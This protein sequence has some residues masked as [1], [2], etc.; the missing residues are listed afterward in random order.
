MRNMKRRSMNVIS[1]Y[2]NNLSDANDL[3][4]EI[5]DSLSYSYDIPS[6]CIK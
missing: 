4:I 3:T 6:E 2:E 5:I 1:S